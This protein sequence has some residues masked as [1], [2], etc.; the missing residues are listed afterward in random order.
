[1]INKQLG[2][3]VFAELGFGGY[4]DAMFGI[5]FRLDCKN[6][7]VGDFLLLDQNID[8]ITKI[9][10]EAK[11]QYMSQL[12]GIPI[13]GIFDGNVLQSWRILTEVI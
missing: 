4:Q 9:L 13:E 2:K 5:T 3:I 6:G 1:M 12:G 8:R 10:L 11:V 7:S